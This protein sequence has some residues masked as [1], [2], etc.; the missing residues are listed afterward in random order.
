MN[1]NNHIESFFGK[2]KEGLPVN[3]SVA[4]LLRLLRT[5]ERIR[6]SELTFEDDKVGT[7]INTTYVDQE[8]KTLVRLTT[9]FVARNAGREYAKATAKSHLYHYNEASDGVSVT[10]TGTL[11]NNDVDL[12]SWTCSCAFATTM[13]L[14]R[15]H[16]IAFRISKD[17]Q[18]LIP[19]DAVA[20]RW[21]RLPRRV[22]Q[23]PSFSYGCH[24]VTDDPP[25]SAPSTRQARFNEA[26]RVLQ[27]LCSEI[28]EISDVG[29]YTA[30]L[31]FVVDQWNNARRRMRT[32]P[33]RVYSEDYPSAGSRG[34]PSGEED[35]E[36]SE[37]PTQL[38]LSQPHSLHSD[39]IGDVPSID[40][41]H[42]QIPRP[43]LDV[44][45]DT[46]PRV[47]GGYLQV[48]VNLNP[49]AANVGRPAVD[50]REVEARA[51]KS[52]ANFDAQFKSRR[53]NGN[54]TLGELLSSLEKEKPSL[55]KLEKRLAGVNEKHRELLACQPKYLRLSNPT[56]VRDVYFFLP[57]LLAE[58]CFKILP[59]NCNDTAIEVDTSQENEA[60][61]QV[62]NNEE[63]MDVVKI[64]RLQFR[65][66]DVEIMERARTLKEAAVEGLRFVKWLNNTVAGRVPAAMQSSVTKL[67]AHV[68]SMYPNCLVQGLADDL[69][70]CTLQRLQP[71]NWFD[72]S[73]IRALL[74]RLSS[75]FVGFVGTNVQRT[76]MARR[77]GEDREFSAG[78]HS[79]VRMHLSDTTIKIIAVPVLF[80]AGKGNH[81]TCIIFDKTKRKVVI[82]DSRNG[83][84][85]RTR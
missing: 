46:T 39:E 15:R 36:Q 80:G 2:L 61:T 10:V 17:T 33:A 75:Q 67:A 64:K 32:A 81:W 71:P 7:N 59:P 6:D 60:S 82:Y 78:V 16:A 70:Y 48:E 20:T 52:R 44:D 41:R 28:A 43:A 54:I 27:P 66:V 26:L 1:T 22:P 23:V 5:K 58:K 40:T 84:A 35:E 50:R 8:M 31:Q 12:T 47:A 30:S 76:T 3:P 74:C 34:K 29:E 73:L 85:P 57:R 65:R 45:G 83:T 19:L 53:V 77:L 79:Q 9:H 51:R 11:S 69:K 4:T 56:V 72:D 42:V 25:Q 37:P 63:T 21:S 18:P 38:A 68:E 62:I 49:H 13:K 24:Q 55:E 14:P